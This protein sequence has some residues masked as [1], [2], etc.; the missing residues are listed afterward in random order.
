MIR[1]PPDFPDNIKFF[2]LVTKAWDLFIENYFQLSIIS[3]FYIVLSILL[4]LIPFIGSFIAHLLIF[5]LVAFINDHRIDNVY[6][7]KSFFW[8]FASLKN[9][10]AAFNLS[11]LGLPF[12][13]L[14]TITA[15]NF[16]K[17]DELTLIFLVCFSLPFTF[18]LLLISVLSTFIIIL[19]EKNLLDSIKRSRE[20][21][22]GHFKDLI[23][24]LLGILFTNILGVI[25]II[26]VIISSYLSIVVMLEFARFLIREYELKN[27]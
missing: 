16:S 19:E 23:V 18:Y 1:I 12:F 15:V 22:H 6:N 21:L 8:P 3:I 11:I 7:M 20:I 24:I 14:L 5:G 4:S 13:T 17:F 10:M 2:Y 27:L 26:G 25:T 9:F